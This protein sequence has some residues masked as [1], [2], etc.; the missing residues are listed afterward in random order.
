M[1]NPFLIGKSI[2]LRSLTV[3][4]IDDGYFRWFND[5]ETSEN[6]SHGK[7]PEN[8]ESA[9][10]FF[11]GLASNKIVHFAIVDKENDIHIGCCSL[12]NID[13]ISRSAEMARIIGEKEY[14]SKGI[15]TEV[16]KLLLE[17]GFNSLN[18]NRIWVGNI[19]NNIAAIKSVDKL[20]FKTE[21][22]LRSTIFKNNKY[23]DVVIRGILK[24][25]Y[26]QKN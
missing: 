7:L 6:N 15:G 3:A 2:Y 22:V 25:E 1:H 18:L 14:R 21:G 4:D 20:G 5:K 8:R 13:W 16:A 12:Q 11:E 17:Y 9:M 26:F 10:R 19:S 24:D 23:H